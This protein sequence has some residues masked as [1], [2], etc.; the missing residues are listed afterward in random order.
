MNYIA[1]YR[2][3]RPQKFSEVAGQKVIVQTLKNAL[4]RNQIGHAY[5]F[6]GPRGTGKTSIAKIFGK[7]VNCLHMPAEDACGECD[8]CR[9]L[10]DGSIGDIIEIDAASNSRVEDMREL[11][12]NANFSPSVC[13][14]KVYILDEVHMLSQSAFNAL[15]KTLEEP[16]KHV[17]FILATTEV[18]KIPPTILS[19][20][21]RFDFR[22]IEVKDI[23]SKLNEIIDEEG[24]NIDPDATQAI[25]EN[26]EGA[27]RDALSL[28][29]QVISFTDDH[30]SIDDVH[31]VAGSVSSEVL[32]N[33][34]LAILDK[35]TNEVM[36]ILESLIDEGKEITKIVADLTMALRDILRTKVTELKD[37]RYEAIASRIKLEKI[38]FYLDLLNTLQQD[39]KFTN[40]KRVYV[41][42]ALIKMMSHEVLDNIN[43]EAEIKD[44]KRQILEINDQL[45]SGNFT[46]S[47]TKQN[48]KPLVTTAEIEEILNNG[49]NQ[50]RT[51]IESQW[52][53]NLTKVPD[54][55]EKTAEMLIKSEVVAGSDRELVLT[56]NDL[57]LAHNLYQ[58]N[59]KKQ[60]LRLIKQI[61]KQIKNYYVVLSSDWEKILNVFTDQWKSGCKKPIL[62]KIDLK[63]YEYEKVTPENKTVSLAKEYFG[64]DKVIIKE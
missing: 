60:V 11:I 31:K 6:S 61:D 22:N 35:D 18:H 49:N 63:I 14:Y 5:L 16:P 51:F 8:V 43:N 40:Q 53:S 42:L 15:L 28:L 58:D 37:P 54:G 3:Y 12:S 46:V 59:V 64:D 4:L 57:D 24:I 9:G 56:V 17:I 33:M 50:K 47:E 1:L 7:A 52:L 20:C 26:A 62:P 10:Q 23:V 48:K 55:L 41:E 38:Y 39:I 45:A 34:V 30:I 19:R 29:D 36:T 25:A 21:Q 32:G 2:Q 44:L 13:K 27:L